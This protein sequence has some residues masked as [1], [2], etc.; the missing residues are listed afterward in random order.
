ML[1]NL[2]FADAPA[3]LGVIYLAVVAWPLAKTDWRERRLPNRLVLPAFPIT[4]I[5]QLAAVALGS[6]WGRLF[7]A[8]VLGAAAFGVGLTLNHW[9]GLG[10]GDVKLIA[11]LALALGW[12]GVFG[13]IWALILAF[14]FAGFVVGVL[15]L[16]GKVKRNPTSKSKFML[17]LATGLP[18]GLQSSIP[19]GPYLLIGFVLALAF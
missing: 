15:F 3:L 8:L 1:R 11:A 16:L 10:M 9:A 18:I 13:V 6:D 19:L 2:L 5:G 7:Q 17:G 14:G 12:W 4:L